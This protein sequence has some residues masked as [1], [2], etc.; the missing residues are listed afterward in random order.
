M[1]TDYKI[2]TKSLAFRLQKVLPLIINS[3]QTGYIKGRYIGENIRTISDLI[4]YTSLMNMPGVI[5]LIDFEKAFDTIKWSFPV[6]SLEY[7]NLGKMFVNWIK[8]IYKN[9]EST[10]MNNGH[11]TNRFPISRGIRQGC[12]VSPYLFIIAAEVL[13]ISIR[14]RHNIKGITIK[15]TTFKLSQ[16]A[17]DTTLLLMDF[18]SVKNALLCLE[19]FQQYQD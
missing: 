7:F 14:A 3:D 17:D 5:L 11:C 19:D 10:V 4:E 12:P 1:N 8:V 13:S 2:L 18:E 6:K 9:T 15:D 16:L